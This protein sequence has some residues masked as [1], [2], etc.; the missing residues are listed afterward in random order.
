MVPD[1]QRNSSLFDRLKA[2]LSNKKINMNLAFV[3]KHDEEQDMPS[4]DAL[5]TNF[6]DV[7]TNQLNLKINN[8]A[9]LILIL[10]NTKAIF[11]KE[12]WERSRKD[13]KFYEKIMKDYIYQNFPATYKIFDNWKKS[14]RAIMSFHIG[15]V[16]NDVLTNKDYQDVKAFIG[17]NYRMF[18]GKKL[19]PKFSWIK[20]LM[21]G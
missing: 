14:N 19:A 16:D 5:F 21:G 20:A 12:D 6:I 15:D 13:P 9:G 3:L 4:C 18:T 17:L 8:R 11:G 10:P 7:V 1:E 2:F